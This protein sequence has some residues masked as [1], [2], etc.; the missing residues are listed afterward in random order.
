MA[1]QINIFIFGSCVSRDAIGYL[2][3]D[4][5]S[6]SKYIA[7]QSLI[8]SFSPSLRDHPA[9]KSTNLDSGFQQEMLR[10][11]FESSLVA[12][13]CDNAHQI[14]LLLIDLVDERGGVYV[15]DDGSVISNSLVVQTSG[16]LNLASENYRLVRFGSDEHFSLWSNAFDML[17]DLLGKTGLIGH[18]ILLDNLW[19]RETIQG[20]TFPLS[21]GGVDPNLM[22]DRFQRY[23]SYAREHVGEAVVKV[24]DILCVA[25]AKHKW[26]SAPFHYSDQFY[27]YV[28][29]QIRRRS[30]G[31]NVSSS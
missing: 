26:G 2:P 12:E 30:E 27:F 14:D 22:N 29:H 28:S 3:A 19:A 4:S 6:L 31:L 16:A 20:E 17:V 21:E 13:L 25:D 8:S 9:L 15:K 24:P 1:T 5:Y 11:D 10:G 18:L 23:Y 7:R